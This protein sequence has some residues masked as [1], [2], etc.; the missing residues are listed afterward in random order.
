[1]KDVHFYA[2]ISGI[3]FGMWP[4]FMNRSGVDGF[5][6]AALFSGITF[7]T[8]L[9]FALASGQLQKIEVTP[10]LF[11]ALAAGIAAGLGVLIFNTMLAKVTPKEVGTMILLMI[12]VQLSVP[13]VYHMIQGGDYSPR[14]IVGVLGAFIVACLLA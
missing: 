5:A 10:L 3:F 13:A 2:I 1:V 6:S 7:A 4:L 8:I 9:P 11:F 14:K 12:M